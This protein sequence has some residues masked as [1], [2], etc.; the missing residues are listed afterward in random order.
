M[1]FASLAVA[2][3]AMSV[4]GGYLPTTS[5]DGGGSSDDHS[6]ENEEIMGKAMVVVV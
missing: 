4:A 2:L 5:G 3:S 6:G 1:A